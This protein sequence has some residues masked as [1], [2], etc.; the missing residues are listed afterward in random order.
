[1]TFAGLWIYCDDYG[2]GEDDPVFIA[3]SIYPRRQTI[4]P[5]EVAA[6]LQALDASGKLCRYSVGGTALLHLPSWREHQ[7]V[8]HPTPSKFPPCPRCD[9]AVFTAWWRDD[10]TRTDRYRRAEKALRATRTNGQHGVQNFS[11]V[12]REGFPKDSGVPREE[13]A[14]DSR[15]TLTQCSSVQGS[16]VQAT[17]G[18]ELWMSRAPLWMNL[19]MA[20]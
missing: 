9:E 7:R 17:A 15:M 12:S 2:R 6:D 11:G 13:F 10:D 19:G 4:G 16:S 8:D 1:M 20:S 14:N 3:A 5:D 18:A